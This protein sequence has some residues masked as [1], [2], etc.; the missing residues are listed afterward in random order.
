MKPVIAVESKNLVVANAFAEVI[1][2][3]MSGEK[4]SLVILDK[5]DDIAGLEDANNFAPDTIN[6]I[7]VIKDAD[8]VLSSRKSMTSKNKLLSY[9]ILQ[10]RQRNTDWILACSNFEKLDKRIKY[11]SAFVV[12]VDDK[13]HGWY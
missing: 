11:Q 1:G 4:Q 12:R 9:L 5:I 7:M 6:K 3:G 10:S 13:C 2:R 8:N